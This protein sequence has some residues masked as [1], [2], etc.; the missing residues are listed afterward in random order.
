MA[1]SLGVQAELDLGAIWLTGPVKGQ[2]EAIQELANLLRRQD[3]RF[4]TA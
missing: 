3:F 2:R 4:M 1:S